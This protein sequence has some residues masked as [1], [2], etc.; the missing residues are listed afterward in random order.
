[1]TAS[2]TLTYSCEQLFFLLLDLCS[3]LFELDLEV[4]FSLRNSTLLYLLQGH[5]GLFFF[6]LHATKASFG[7]SAILRSWAS[8]SPSGSS[9]GGGVVDTA[10]LE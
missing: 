5:Y 3:I 2:L 10:R 7:A 6:F 1:L 8:S 9:G 4:S